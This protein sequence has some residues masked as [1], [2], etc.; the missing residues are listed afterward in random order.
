MSKATSIDYGRGYDD[1]YAGRSAEAPHS[2]D[3]ALGYE[4]GREDRE[5][6]PAAQPIE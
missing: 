2:P 4:D 5:D 6:D 1:G 3:Y